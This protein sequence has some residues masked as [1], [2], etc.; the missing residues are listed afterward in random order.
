[1]FSA[2]AP[3]AVSGVR[4]GESAEGR[5]GPSVALPADEL[6][7]WRVGL[8]LGR[9]RTAAMHELL[10][11]DERE[12]AARFRFDRDRDRYVAGR[13]LLRCLLGAY[14]GRE[15]AAIAFS[16]GPYGKPSLQDAALHFNLSNSGAVA[17]IALSAS[18]ELGVDLE[19][20]RE[21]FSREHIAERFFSPAE[22]RDLRALAPEEQPTAF[23]RCWTRKE[24]FIKARGDGLSLAL[25]SFDV[26]LQPGQ[27]AMV[28]RTAWSE[29]EPRH[30]GM[31]DLSDDEGGFIA[32]VAT[33][34]TAW[35]LVSRHIDEIFDHVKLS[36]QEDR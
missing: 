23:L 25:D 19:L 4:G 16:Y 9:E 20:A 29:E 27:P 2:G 14:T 3:P 35:R 31:Q 15:P 34:S 10:S 13:G 22:V 28:T 8:E 21:D 5:G 7:V 26:T 24:A 36:D 17:L 11:L 18:A 12:R 1:M 6:H 30:W 33:R 32:A